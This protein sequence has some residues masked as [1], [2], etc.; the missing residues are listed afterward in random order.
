MK[1]LSTVSFSKQAN[2]SATLEASK[3]FAGLFLKHTQVGLHTNENNVT[4][5]VS[6]LLRTVLRL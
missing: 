6:W 1:S 5:A 3:Q 4:P 2:P